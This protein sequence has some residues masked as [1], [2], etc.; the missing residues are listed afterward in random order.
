MICKNFV[1]KIF[2][3][4]IKLWCKYKN[5]IFI[6]FLVNFM[7]FEYNKFIV[8]IYIFIDYKNVMNIKFKYICNYYMKIIMRYMIF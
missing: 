7:I 5:Y 4:C 1:I 8:Y 3:Y 2:Y 6:L